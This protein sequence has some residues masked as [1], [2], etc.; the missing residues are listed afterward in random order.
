M[1][2]RSSSKGFNDWIDDIAKENRCSLSTDLH[3]DYAFYV[4][5]A[6]RIPWP[7]L[8]SSFGVGIAKTQP[9]FE[10]RKTIRVTGKYTARDIYLWYDNRVKR[11]LQPYINL[12]SSNAQA[13]CRMDQEA[14]W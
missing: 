6:K 8:M 9:Y 4:T 12:I 11:L 3:C 7:Y 5:E 10:G 1:I 13:I 14:G 2:G